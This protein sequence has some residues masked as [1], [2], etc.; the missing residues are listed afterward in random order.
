MQVEKIR[1]QQE[2]GTSGSE[3][4]QALYYLAENTGDSR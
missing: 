1:G 3:S 4:Q 2:F